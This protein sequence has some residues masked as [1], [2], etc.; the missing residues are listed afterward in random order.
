MALNDLGG[1]DEDE[2][3]VICGLPEAMLGMFAFQDS[4][5]T[6]DDIAWIGNV[7]TD[8]NCLMVRIDDDRFN[9]AQDQMCI[10]D[11]DCTAKRTLIHIT[12]GLAD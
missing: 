8:A 4:P 3:G 2:F 7:Y 6:A 10:R 12:D 1:L 9:S 5:Y 11:S